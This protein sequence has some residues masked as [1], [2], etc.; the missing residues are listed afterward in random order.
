MNT[1][2]QNTIHH[3]GSGRYVRPVSGGEPRL[4]DEVILRLRMA[5]DAPVR[6][7]LLRTCPD[8]EQMFVELHPEAEPQ[9]GSPCRWWQAR[10]KLTMPQTRYRFLIFAEESIKKA[11]AAFV[12][13]RNSLCSNSFTRRSMTPM[14]S[15]PSC[16]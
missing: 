5:Q 3:D 12:F 7:V 11:I 8:G 10:L 2:Y 1:P 14:E 13:S 4:G 15:S 16:E 6:R 9:P